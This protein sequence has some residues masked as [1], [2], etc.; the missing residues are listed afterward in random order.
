MSY[1]INYI[2]VSRREF[3]NATYDDYAGFIGEKVKNELPGSVARWLPDT[4][5]VGHAVCNLAGE[6]TSTTH[7][8][9]GSYSHDGDGWSV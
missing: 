4:T 6:V 7:Y 3:N 2:M 8:K 9:D 1:V 5:T